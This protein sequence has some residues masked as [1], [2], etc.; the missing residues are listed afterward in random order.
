MM[1]DPKNYFKDYDGNAALDGALRFHDINDKK[2]KDDW[3]LSYGNLIP[4]I[5]IFASDAFGL[6]YGLNENN[7][8]TIF[9]SETGE[10][11]KLGINIE[12]FYK[13]IIDNPDST[14]NLYLFKEAEKCLGKLNIHEHY[15]FKIE[16]AMG[17]EL[18]TDNLIIC[19]SNVH[20][21]QLGKIAQQISRLPV[22]TKI[23]N[24]LLEKEREK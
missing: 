15:A 20:M 4:D 6:M 14:I 8:V 3:G 23:T 9:W 17:G 2:W 12:T 5:R 21:N 18:S 13:R 16:L 10:L 7:E 19:D 11:E 1:I 22:G 24:V